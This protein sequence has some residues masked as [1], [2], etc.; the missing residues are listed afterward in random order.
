MSFK[1]LED[2]RPFH[3]YDLRHVY[4]QMLKDLGVPLSDIQAQLGHSTI[5]LT[6]KYYANFK[7]KNI[8]QSVNKLDEYFEYQN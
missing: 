3:F 1:K 4:G 5:I 2:G 6:E 7:S 8:K